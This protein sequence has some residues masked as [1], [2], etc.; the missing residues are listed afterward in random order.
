MMTNKHLSTCC[1]CL[2]KTDGIHTCTPSAGWRKLE[3]QR[4]ELLSALERAVQS[5]I[6]FRNEQT[7]HRLL[8]LRTNVSY[9]EMHNAMDEARA[10][11]ARA[12]GG[13]A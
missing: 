8:K 7:L 11:I 2:K 12:K 6:M 5:I 10:A 1:R 4:D 9:M 3:E 13:A